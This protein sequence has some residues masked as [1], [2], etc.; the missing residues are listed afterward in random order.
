MRVLLD[1]CVPRRLATLL[2]GH[3]S[4]TVPQMGWSGIRNSKLL[5][6]SAAEFDAFVTV[7]RNL[8]FQNPVA[9]YPIRVLLLSARSNA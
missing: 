4:A 8:A 7:D 6:L 5:E 2:V 9:E 1:E 3:E